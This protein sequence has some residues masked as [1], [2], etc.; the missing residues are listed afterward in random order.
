MMAFSA[1]FKTKPPRIHMYIM[2]LQM[3]EFKELIKI[4]W[5]KK[6]HKILS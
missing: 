5:K 1:S 4:E 3:Y 2:I 6:S